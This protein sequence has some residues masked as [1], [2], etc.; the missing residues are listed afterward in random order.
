[1]KARKKKQVKRVKKW[2]GFSECMEKRK[3]NYPES[4]K[5][6]SNFNE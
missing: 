5:W 1:M 2:V 4:K 3:I 6:M